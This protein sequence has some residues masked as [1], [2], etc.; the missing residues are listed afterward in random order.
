MSSIRDITSYARQLNWERLFVRIIAVL[1]GVSMIVV[2]LW[3]E[4]A[5]VLSIAIF[6]ELLNRTTR[7]LARFMINAIA[8]NDVNSEIMRET[9]IIDKLGG[10]SK[11]EDTRQ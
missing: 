11:I 3:V 2:G 8:K 1:F 6:G 4:G 9:K 5:I 7:R 10:N